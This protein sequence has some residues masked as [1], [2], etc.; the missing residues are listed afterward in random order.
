MGAYGKIKKLGIGLMHW[1][2]YGFGGWAARRAMNNKLHSFYLAAA[3][4]MDPAYKKAVEDFWRPYTLRFDFGWHRMYASTGSRDPRFLPDDIYLTHIDRYMNDRDLSR[5]LRD[6]NYAAL[7]FPE[8]NLPKTVIRIVDG[9]WMDGQYQLF[10]KE[11]ALDAAMAEQELICKPTLDSGGGKN[12]R[13]WRVEDGRQSLLAILNEMGE[14]VVVQEVIAQHET[15]N[16]LHKDSVNT[17]RLITFLWKGEVHALSAILRM[18][19]NGNRMDNGGA[20]GIAAGILPDGRLKSRAFT[21][22]GIVYEQHPQ[23]A[24]F[25]DCVVPNFQDLQET[26]K[27]AHVR[28]SHSKLISWDIAVGTDGKPI[29]VESNLYCGGIKLLQLNNGPLFGELT[30]EVLETV[31]GKDQGTRKES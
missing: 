31:F 17:I 20:G 7:L 16:R 1:M 28:L 3:P 2:E 21:E 26:F 13:F 9:T 12:I 25:E 18:G 30:Q 19:I 5:G 10:T 11:E 14:N 24:R 22:N 27:R 4:E 8:I 15:L 23:G 6:K 29:L